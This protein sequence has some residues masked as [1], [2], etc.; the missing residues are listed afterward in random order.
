MITKVT[1]VLLSLSLSRIALSNLKNVG[2]IFSLSCFACQLQAST[3]DQNLALPPSTPVS[4]NFLVHLNL[5]LNKHSGELVRKHSPHWQ[6]N[7]FLQKLTEVDVADLYSGIKKTKHKNVF[8]YNLLHFRWLQHIQ[9]DVS[10]QGWSECYQ[11]IVDKKGMT[12]EKK[13]YF[14]GNSPVLN[15][16]EWDFSYCAGEDSDSDKETFLYFF[17][18]ASGN[19][20]NWINRKAMAE[21]RRLWREKGKLPRWISVSMG[22]LGL[23]LEKEKEDRFFQFVVPYIEKRFGPKPSK[24]VTRL[25]LSVSMGGANSSYVILR[26]PEFF[27]AAF[28]VCPAIST[29][30]PGADP[31]ATDN[32]LVRTPA[33][34]IVVNAVNRVMPK[35]MHNTKYFSTVDPLLLGQHA[36]SAKTPPLYI[37][38]SSKDEFGFN[39]GGKIFALLARM[40]G[41]EVKYEEIA[42][43]HCVLEPKSVVKFLAGYQEHY[44]ELRDSHE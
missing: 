33:F 13:L 10:S 28:L 18:G 38:T 8:A 31:I 4:K 44:Q 3:S 17:H 20:H 15:P 9:S 11:I 35:E 29:L 40:N 39:E 21:V 27:Q 2:F 42:G 16:G 30:N 37:Q 14:T 6:E 34:R 12:H 1:Q 23:L 24:N 19:P 32:Y 26:K 36:L 7:Q 25:N 5:E 22:R 43:L 41:A